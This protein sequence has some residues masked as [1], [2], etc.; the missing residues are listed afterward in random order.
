M[1]CLLSVARINRAI[2]NIPRHLCEIS[3]F[4]PGQAATEQ[5]HALINE[6]QWLGAGLRIAGWH[7]SDGTLA[8]AA[9]SVLLPIAIS[10]QDALEEVEGI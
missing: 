3:A 9:L 10:L 6:L 2:E 7:V 4:G 8:A 1:F 5:R